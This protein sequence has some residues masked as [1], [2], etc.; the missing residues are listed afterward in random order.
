MSASTQV[1]VDRPVH[2]REATPPAAPCRMCGGAR[3][4]GV[5]IHNWRRGGSEWVGDTDCTN[6]SGSG[7]EPA[8]EPVA[9]I[10]GKGCHA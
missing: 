7:V 2:R 5:F 8:A 9:W 10:D 1:P 3:V 6:C 4:V